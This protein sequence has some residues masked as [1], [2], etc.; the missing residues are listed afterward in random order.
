MMEFQPGD[1]VTIADSV[2][3]DIATVAWDYIK[4]HRRAVVRSKFEHP[5]DLDDSLKCYSCEWAEDFV[6]GIDCWKTTKPKRGHFVTAKHIHLNFE[7]SRAV[8]TVPNVELDPSH[9]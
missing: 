3:P 4:D 6:G 9:Y 7:E 8:V 1:I 2:R 5:D